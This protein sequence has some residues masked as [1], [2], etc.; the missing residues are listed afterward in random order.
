MIFFL[1]EPYFNN[2]ILE[3]I[4]VIHKLS[5]LLGK[6]VFPLLI[7]CKRGAEYTNDYEVLTN[8]YENPWSVACERRNL[9][10][11]K[12]MV[13]NETPDDEISMCCA[14]YYGSL[15]II[16]YLHSV[17]KEIDKYCLSWLTV[18]DASGRYEFLEFLHSI[19]KEIPDVVPYY[20]ASNGFLKEVKFLHSIGKKFTF[21]SLDEACYNGHIET[22]KFLYSIGVDSHSCMYNASR[23]GHLD[24]VKFFYEKGKFSQWVMSTAIRRRRIDVVKFLLDKE[25]DNVKISL[26]RLY[27]N[28]YM[29][30][31]EWLHNNGIDCRDFLMWASRDHNYMAMEK[32]IAMGIKD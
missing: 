32:F 23:A 31:I 18:R 4:P 9:E 17:G 20:M 15:E 6:N 16:K 11:I 13:F 28:N 2:M 27:E 7:T 12:F 29:Q 22:V 24:I 10:W 1:E 14:F 26:H 21:S 5:E 8:M 30:T 25:G 19:G 3:H